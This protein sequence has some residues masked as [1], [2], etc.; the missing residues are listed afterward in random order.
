MD[1]W[2][3]YPGSEER[4]KAAERV[5]DDPVDVEA[6]RRFLENEGNHLIIAYV[7]GDP[8]GFVSGTELT[9]PDQPWPEVFVNEL[10]VDAAYRERGIGTQ[11]VLTLWAIAQ[12]RG[13]RGMWVLANGS[14]EPALRVYAA[15]GGVRLP[16][17]AL[18]QWGET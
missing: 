6:T 18:F 2:H 9:H 7:E 17:Q 13:C 4:V 3:A 8:A 11:L 10:G 16:E 15:A 14:N 1:L 5:F 12:G